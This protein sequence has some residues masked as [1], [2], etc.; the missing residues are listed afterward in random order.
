MIVVAQFATAVVLFAVGWWGRRVSAQSFPAPL[1]VEERE[2][3]AVACRRGAVA[4]LACAVL[5][6]LASVMTAAQVVADLRTG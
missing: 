5:V 2:R 4:C 1:P 6:S 3:K